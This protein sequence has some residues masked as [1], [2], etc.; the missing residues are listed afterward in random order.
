L[1]LAN[2]ANVKSRLINN[3]D[4]SE[5]E[6]IVQDR[7]YHSPERSPER[8]SSNSSSD[9]IITYDLNWRSEEVSKPFEVSDNY[10]NS[11]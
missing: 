3:Y 2:L 5:L 6:R 11:H 9:E 10:L 1:A 8:S 7:R 4:V